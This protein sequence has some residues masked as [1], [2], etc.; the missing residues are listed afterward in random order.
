MTRGR[1]PAALPALPQ[2]PTLPQR[3]APAEVRAPTFAARAGAPPT[4]TPAA[5][6]QAPGLQPDVEPDVGADVGPGEPTGTDHHGHATEDGGPVAQKPAA[7]AGRTSLGVG[8]VSLGAAVDEL[9]DRAATRLTQP[10]LQGELA[11]LGEAARRMRTR[12]LVVEELEAWTQHRA[13]RGLPSLDITDETQLVAAVLAALRGLGP[14]EPILARDDVEDIF[15][16]G[17]APTM[18]RLADGSKVPGVPLGDTDERVRALIA[19]LAGAQAEASGREFSQAQPLLALRLPAIGI[20]GARLSAAID[21]TP[22]PVGTIRVH[23][24]VDVTLDDLARMGMID[25]SLHATLTAAVLA[26]MNILVTGDKG[27]GKTVLLRAL[28]RQ[29]PLNEAV[30]TVEDNRELGL[31]V[32]TRKDTRGRVLRDEAG[33]PVPLRPAALLKAY[34][35]RPANAEGVGA[36]EMADL[37]RQAL[38]DSPDRVVIGESRGAD[39]VDILSAISSGS[40]GVMATIHAESARGVF[41]RIVQMIRSVYPPL[42]TDFALRGAAYVDLVVQVARDRDHHRFVS[43]VIAMDGVNR[44]LGDN[45]YPRFETIYAPGTDGRARPVRPPALRTLDRL[46]DV[47]WDEGWCRPQ[48]ADWPPWADRS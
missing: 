29:I 36:I 32:L 39:M 28:C 15:F 37:L 38:R 43:E 30:V 11:L 34:E 4:P 7:G 17:A 46:R 21:V 45:G 26:G 10:E 24:H 1:G 42:P 47:G 22:H 8:R 16:N 25:S 27:V 44:S 40:R 23:R 31:H 18:L 48:A 12:A 20:M 3:P 9:R 41:D 35:G 19:A 13:A 14:L 33:D 5:Q 2:L 6:A